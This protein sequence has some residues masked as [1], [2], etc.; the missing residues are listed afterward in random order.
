MT[1]DKRLEDVILKALYSSYEMGKR[2]EP[3]S[4]MESEFDLPCID[5]SI[6]PKLVTAIK[7]LIL[8]VLPEEREIDP[9]N[10]PD[11]YIN[12]DIG[13]NKCL[14]EVKKTIGEL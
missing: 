1:T 11:V 8:S 4:D 14:A 5:L 3:L 2:L 13:F 6:K 7:S 12:H 9:A 10:M